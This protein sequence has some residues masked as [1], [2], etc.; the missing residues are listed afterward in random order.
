MVKAKLDE[1]KGNKDNSEEIDAVEHGEQ[2]EEEE[3]LEQDEEAWVMLNHH[4]CC[5]GELLSN[6]KI[7]H[8]SQLAIGWNRRVSCMCWTF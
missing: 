4:F 7:Q 5:Y 1:I 8:V 2:G 6:S 3:G